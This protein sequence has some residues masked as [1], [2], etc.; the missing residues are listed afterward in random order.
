MSG[1]LF[2]RHSVHVYIII[3]LKTFLRLLSSNWR[4]V[5]KIDEFAFSRCYIF[6]S[7]R[8]NVDIV[9]HYDNNPFGISA[10]TN[11]DDLECPIHLKMRLADGTLVA[12]RADNA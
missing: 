3:Y 11:K 8:N 10:D 9:V 4:G 1:S 12:F 5:V 2:L 6:V 7:F